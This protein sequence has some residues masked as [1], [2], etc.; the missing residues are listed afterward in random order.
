M[1]LL[2][3]IIDMFQPQDREN[4]A[5]STL[6]NGKSS[7]NLSKSSFVQ[8]GYKLYNQLPVNLKSEKSMWKFKKIAKTW[9]KLNIMIKP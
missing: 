9:I 3:Y 6:L 8:R 1:S 7:L 5:G 4:R 2:V